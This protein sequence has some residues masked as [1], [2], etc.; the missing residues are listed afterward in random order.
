MHNVYSLPSIP[1]TIR[2]LHAAAGF[3]VKETWLDAIKAGNYVTWPGLTTTAVRKHFPDSD[4]TQQGHMKQQRQGVRSTKLTVND[5]ES[6]APNPKKMH[7][8]FIKIYNVSETMY[9]DQT[10]RFPATSSRGNQY[11][12]VLVEVDGNYID[13]EPMKNKSEGSLIRAYLILWA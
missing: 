9:T 6:P 8:V 7:D 13:V 10:G 1:H 12:M 4:E 2:Y 3:P 11:I 5:E